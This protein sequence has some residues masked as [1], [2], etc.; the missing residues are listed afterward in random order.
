[1][2]SDTMITIEIYPVEPVIGGVEY[3]HNKT[4][5]EKL[6]FAGS[7]VPNG[8]SFGFRILG[9]DMEP[10]LPRGCVA[11]FRACLRVENG[12]VGVF[13]LNKKLCCKR[14]DINK[15]RQRVRLLSTNPDYEPIIAP[16]PRNLPT[17]GQLLGYTMNHL[18]FQPL[19]N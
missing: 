9:D 5:L 7:D 4:V 1:M 13:S 19:T 3:Y 12:Q 11:F 10:E 15:D 2:N 17:F 16:D 14:I 18:V 6:I 8:T